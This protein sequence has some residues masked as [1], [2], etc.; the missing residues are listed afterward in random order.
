[1]RVLLVCDDY[2]PAGFGGGIVMALSIFN[3]LKA[4]GYPVQVVCTSPRNG[5]GRKQEGVYPV[6]TPKHVWMG[7]EPA[8]ITEGYLT[9][10]MATLNGILRSFRPTVIFFM[11]LWGLLTETIQWIDDLPLPKVYRLGD[12]WPRLH[13]FKR[14]PNAAPLTANGVIANNLDL[15]QRSDIWFQSSGLRRCI[16]NGVDLRIFTYQTPRLIREP[17][18]RPKRLL[19]SGR[20]VPHKGIHIA[21][22]VLRELLRLDSPG[23]SLTL[24]GPWP[25]T[26][27]EKAVRRQAAGLPVRITG[28]LSQPE[29]AR[30]LHDHDIFLFTSP[31]RDRTRTIEGCPSALLEAW[32]CGIPVVAR[33]TVGQ[34]ELLRE[35]SNCLSTHSDDPSEYAGRVLA[36]SQ[37]TDLIRRLSSESVFMVKKRYDRRHMI[38]NIA[39]FVRDC[40][41][42]H[43][44]VERRIRIQRARL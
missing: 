29:L 19:V 21:V 36:L 28:L 40:C 42:D 11:H 24:A 34:K 1:M 25:K 4:M 26:N 13:Y 2:P 3:G 6:L 32:A 35:G 20:M 9:K 27:Y 8:G 18:D 44:D 5:A 22:E 17:G 39:G 16:R 30:A 7:E 41:R 12:E 33:Q 31:E 15:L 43:P 37:R 38:A 10:D 14:R 23:W